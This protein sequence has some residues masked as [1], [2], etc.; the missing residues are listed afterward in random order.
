M[1]KL[2]YFMLNRETNTIHISD[3]TFQDIHSIRIAKVE[4]YQNMIETRN[5][6]QMLNPNM[7][8]LLHQN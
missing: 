4:G 5:A 3:G 6:L 8:I 1:N 7:T 2:Y